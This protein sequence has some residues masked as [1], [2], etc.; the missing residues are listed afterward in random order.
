M[1]AHIVR[2][3]DAF[4]SLRAGGAFRAGRAAGVFIAFLAR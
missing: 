4:R 1:F 3:I 2:R